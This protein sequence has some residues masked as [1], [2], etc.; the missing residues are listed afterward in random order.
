MQKNNKQNIIYKPSRI[1]SIFFP[2]KDEQK[3]KI[4]FCFLKYFWS[5]F[6]RKNED[7]SYILSQKYIYEYLDINKIIQR[8]QDVDKL[9]QIVLNDDQKF[10]FDLIPKPE[11]SDSKTTI[12]SKTT[13]G[14][15]K[16]MKSRIKNAKGNFLSKKFEKL[17]DDS[18]FISQRILVLLDEETKQMIKLKSISKSEGSKK[19][20]N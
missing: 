18:N 3:K 6:R 4:R 20:L 17:K 19:F 15:E 10:F 5:K 1:A 12:R 2:K 7:D 16:I 9:K 13:F 8:L 14:A 11:I